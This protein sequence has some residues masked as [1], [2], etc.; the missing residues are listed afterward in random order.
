MI[1]LGDRTYRMVVDHKDAW[2]PEAFRD[3]YSEVLDRYDYIV[4]D[5]GYNQLRLK[6]FFKE[7]SPKATKDTSI[8]ALQDYLHEYCNF[9]CAYFVIERISNPNRQYEDQDERAED[10][11]DGGEAS[12]S[13][14][15][16]SAHR[17]DHHGRKE[18]M[19]RNDRPRS[20]DKPQDNANEKTRENEKQRGNDRAEVND[21]SRSQ[22]ENQG[23]EASKRGETG[24]AAAQQPSKNNHRRNRF[25]NRKHRGKGDKSAEQGQQKSQPTGAAKE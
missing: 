15:H 13:R 18:H 24:Q 14:R 6:G 12:A 21:K 17:Q 16:P 5:W 7:S 2:N 9:G 11:D 8:A 25:R 3:R 1:H 10:L 23:S 19:R 20:N 22:E 4:G